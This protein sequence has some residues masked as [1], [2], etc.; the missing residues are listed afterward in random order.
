[1]IMFTIPF[2]T[3]EEYPFEPRKIVVKNKDPKAEYNLC[4][5]LGR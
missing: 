4:E 5:E 1:M 2:W 3:D